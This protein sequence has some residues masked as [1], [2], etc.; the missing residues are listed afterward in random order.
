MLVNN[1]SFINVPSVDFPSKNNL[2]SQDKYAFNPT[3]SPIYQ[4]DGLQCD[5]FCKNIK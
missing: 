4:F 5:D 3:K 2:V 1:R